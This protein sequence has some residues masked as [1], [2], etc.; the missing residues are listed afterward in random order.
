MGLA[1]W[2]ARLSCQNVRRCR[3]LTRFTAIVMELMWPFHRRNTDGANSNPPQIRAIYKGISCPGHPRKTRNCARW[4]PVCQK[5]I[6]REEQYS[7]RPAI[8]RNF[9]FWG[10]VLGFG[11][12]SCY[13]RAFLRNL[14]AQD[15]IKGI[16]YLVVIYRN[17][18]VLM[19]S[20]KQIVKESV[21][22]NLRSWNNY[23]LES[24]TWL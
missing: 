21:W 18:L 7:M 20:T 11:G 6:G 16:A 8:V 19:A 24:E 2:H 12:K 9:S 3:E 5:H 10:S 4:H 13:P 22:I 17:I 14:I 15:W 1:S 23:R